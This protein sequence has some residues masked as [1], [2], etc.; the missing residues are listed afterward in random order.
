MQKNWRELHQLQKCSGASYNFFY[1]LRWDVLRSPFNPCP[2]VL[3]LRRFGRLRTLT[4]SGNP[5][6]EDPNYKEYIIAHLSELVYLDFR[7]VDESA[8]EVA[9][10]RY[11]YSIEELVHDET[12]A[13]RKEDEQ[14]SRDKERQRHKVIYLSNY[15]S[16]KSHS[17]AKRLK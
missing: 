1:Q 15:C 14:E 3:Y 6:S 2:Q 5:F 13:R 7:L 4:L 9:I 11:K 16:R 10:E 12:I 8:R 17:L